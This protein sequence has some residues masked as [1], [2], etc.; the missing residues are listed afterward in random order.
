MKINVLLGA[1]RNHELV[2]GEFYLFHPRYWS[3][4]KGNYTDESVLNF[5]ASFD[6][7]RPFN[8]DD[9]N[10]EDYFE[11]Y[12][13]CLDKESKYDMCVRIDCKPSELAEKSAEEC[14]DIRDA[15]DCSLYPECYE[16][17]G[18]SWYFESVSSGQ[19]D[20]RDCMEI[21]T[22]KSI[23]DKLH[24]LWNAYHLNKVDSD[25][26]AQMKNLAKMCK[27]IQEN[28]EEWIKDYIRENMAI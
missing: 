28:E 3:K 1:N 16:I 20:S 12:V 18:E 22:N 15:V 8:G 9:Y 23:Y 14:Y 11:G 6:V 24:E 5:S 21:Y 17:N 26:I 10:L 2:F 4:E 27:D 19:Y 25:V 7:V 13:E